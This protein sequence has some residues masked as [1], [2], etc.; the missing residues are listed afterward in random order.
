MDKFE[1]DYLLYYRNWH[2][3]TIVDKTPIG[4]LAFQLLEP[5]RLLVQHGKTKRK[6]KRRIGHCFDAQE[7]LAEYLRENYVKPYLKG[8]LPKYDAAAKNADVPVNGTLWQLRWESVPARDKAVDI[9]LSSAVRCKGK[10]EH[11]IL[12]KGTISKYVDIPDFAY[13]KLTE[14]RRP[15][16]PWFSDLLGLYLLSAYGGIWADHLCFFTSEIPEKIV[17]ADFF[18]IQRSADAGNWNWGDFEDY[19]SWNLSNR[20]KLF[21]GFIAAKKGN[22]LIDALKDILS[23]YWR[24]E[25]G[26]PH[27][28]IFQILFDVLLEYPQLRSANWE[29]ADNIKPYFLQTILAKGYDSE[30]QLGRV[31]AASFVHKLTYGS[32]SDY[33]KKSTSHRL[34]KFASSTD[35]FPVPL[36]KNREN[37]KIS[38]C[39]VCGGES[40]SIS[41]KYDINTLICIWRSTYGINPIPPAYGGET[42]H[43]LHCNTCG[44]YFY[45]L[46]IPDFKEMYNALSRTEGYPEEKWEYNAAI[47]IINAVKPRNLFEIGAG[48]GYFLKKARCFVPEV[49][50]SEIN[51]GAVSILNKMG[52]RVRPENL[53]EIKEKFDIV[54]SFQVFEHMPDIG[55]VFCDVVSLL[56]KGGRLIIAVPNPDGILKITSG[57]L[58]VPPHHR[59]D[60]TRE[61]FLYLAKKHNLAVEYYRTEPLSKGERKVLK[62]MDI[63]SIQAGHSCLVCFKV[64]G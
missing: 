14:E 41:N 46:D 57:I 34:E 29:I 49:S 6:L 52:V 32:F 60:F 48:F 22:K 16:I 23:E 8:E 4:K 38:N 3:N 43:K 35:I 19:F 42:M 2:G 15:K 27:Y 64:E 56:S 39:P 58:C 54:C 50:C 21:N 25:T 36:V 37:K 31:S 30:K 44:S 12:T 18:A 5:F 61:S 10:L 63:N 7:L 40:Y 13:V 11:M 9:C 47:G 55:T 33:K 28:F 26:S 53:V 1:F 17:N 59:T 62:K 51:P 24:R 20:V 45:D